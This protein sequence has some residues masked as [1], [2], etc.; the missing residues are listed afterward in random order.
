MNG[1]FPQSA[2]RNQGILSKRLG[3]ELDNNVSIIDSDSESEDPKPTTSSSFVTNSVS[4]GIVQNNADEVLP[5]E[6]NEVFE[7]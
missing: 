3:E 7:V 2:N 4:D 5:C 1:S 6:S